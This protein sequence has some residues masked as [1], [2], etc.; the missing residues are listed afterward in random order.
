MNFDI[1]IYHSLNK[2]LEEAWKSFEN[3][4]ENYCFQ[5]YDWLESWIKNYR[6]NSSNFLL[7][8][9]TVLYQNKIICIFPLEIQKKF[10]LKILKWIGDK[11]SDYC[12]PLLRKDF[13]FDKEIFIDL[14]KKIFKE[15]Q[16]VDIVYLEKQPQYINRVKNPFVGLSG[17]YFDSKTYN[18]LLPKKWKNYCNE[19]LKKEFH[20]QNLRKK[21]SLK[22]LG[23]LKF[24][25]YN[26]KDEKIAVLK[27]LF[28]QKN[29]RLS[30]QGIKDILDPKD[31]KFYKR[32]EEG[33]FLNIKTQLSS[34]TLNGELIAIHWGVV[35]KKRFYYLLLSMKDGKLGRYS[36]G[37]LLISLLI[38][39]SISK[40]LEIFDFTLGEENYKKSWSSNVSSLFNFVESRSLKGLYLFFL[41]KIKLILKQIYKQNYRKKM[42]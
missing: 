18:I 16:N 37:R 40:K 24:K 9:T 11:Q 25:I 32:L 14:Y 4:S 30:S 10:K 39:W 6:D 22:K 29:I 7:C 38:R 19:I 15:I 31:F 2:S 8:I 17:N 5:S 13:N 28:Q 35:Y 41:I 23:K 36:P 3:D 34:L 26:N 33:S 42:V 12:S 1:K 21:R 27:E 20:L